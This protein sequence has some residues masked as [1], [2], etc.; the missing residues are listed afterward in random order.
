MQPASVVVAQQNIEKN[1][2]HWAILRYSHKNTLV[3]GKYSLIVMIAAFQKNFGWSS[4]NRIIIIIIIFK[5]PF[6]INDVSFK[7]PGV[8]HTP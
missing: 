5:C 2:S 4:Q 8:I 6:C 7:T 1:G 3:K